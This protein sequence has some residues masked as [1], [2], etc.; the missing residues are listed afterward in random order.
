MKIYIGVLVIEGCGPGERQWLVE[1]NHL[2]CRTPMGHASIRLSIWSWPTMPRAEVPEAASPQAE[3][4][5][6][7]G[8]CVTVIEVL[9]IRTSVLNYIPSQKTIGLLKAAWG[10]RGMN[11]NVWRTSEPG[12]LCSGRGDGLAARLRF[13]TSL[14]SSPSQQRGGRLRALA[15]SR[16]QSIL[17]LQGRSEAVKWCVDRVI[18]PPEHMPSRCTDT[19]G[20]SW[21]WLNPVRPS[22][23]P[24]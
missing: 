19:D 16:S 5:V 10:T 12:A 6:E 20:G 7:R 4:D 15:R 2:N 1:W 21:R 23:S 22:P 9:A 11:P 18:H 13:C 8:L 17:A 24:F 14:S 3:R